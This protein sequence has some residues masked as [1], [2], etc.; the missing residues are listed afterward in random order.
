MKRA[1]NPQ[2]ASAI[3]DVS[4]ALHDINDYYE[5]PLVLESTLSKHLHIDWMGL[6]RVSSFEPHIHI[7]TNPHL[8]F[9]WD[10][11]YQEIAP[12]DNFAASTFEMSE[13]DALIYRHYPDRMDEKNIYA[14]EFARKHTNTEQFMGLLGLKCERFIL[15]Y[16]FYRTDKNNP[17]TCED[18]DFLL[19]VS[20]L[21]VNSSK[22]MELYKDY[23]FKRAA[24]ERLLTDEPI[25]PI[26]FDEKLAPIEIAPE[27]Q[28]MFGMAWG[29]KCLPMIP[30]EIIDWI[31][32]TVAPK[33]RLTPNTGPF[34]L[35]LCLPGGHLSCRAYII[36][37]QQEKLALLIKFRLHESSENFA[38]LKQ[39][40]LT[41]REITALDYLPLGYSNKQIAIAMGIKEVSVKKHLKNAAR[42][43]GAANKT[44]TLYRALIEKNILQFG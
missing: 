25:K 4:Y 36:K 28:R 11:L 1:L 41:S 29:K 3:L 34:S 8:P 44:E 5:L 16:G 24:L 7:T 35:K 14:F 27:T 26:V 39:K 37:T 38:I 23:D 42:K 30:S 6:Y 2:T 20:P 22:T 9:N 12:Y 40:G 21:I 15:A 18:K 10:D 33:G 31:H 43:L 17:F 13:G 32:H 19:K